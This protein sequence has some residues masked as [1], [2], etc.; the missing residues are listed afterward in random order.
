VKEIFLRHSWKGNVRELKN[1]IERLVILV[2]DE[3]IKPE[4]INTAG[5]EVA[6]VERL[7]EIE[8]FKE[9]KRE[10]EKEY[11]LH[12]LSKNDYDPKKTAEKLGIDLSNLYKKIKSYGI[13]I[14]GKG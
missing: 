1:L 2:D 13:K 8:N 6:T 4:H 10:F 7:F 3:E 5:S 9:A 12:H 14:K 11:I